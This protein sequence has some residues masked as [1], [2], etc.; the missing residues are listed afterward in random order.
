MHGQRK[1]EESQCFFLLLWKMK[2][3]ERRRMQKHVKVCSNCPFEMLF[4]HADCK[5]PFKVSSFITGYTGT[6][7]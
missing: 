7:A 1:Q 3:M 4:L 5:H 6:E 2:T